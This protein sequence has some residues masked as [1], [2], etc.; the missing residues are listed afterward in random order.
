MTTPPDETDIAFGEPTLPIVPEFLI[1]ISSLKVT[2]VS[3][4]RVII[5]AAAGL[6]IVPL[7]LIFILS[8]KVT[9]PFSLMSTLTATKLVFPS[10]SVPLMFTS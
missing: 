8:L 10:E 1:L 5:S 6:P 7:F 3:E 2:V 9:S 4:L